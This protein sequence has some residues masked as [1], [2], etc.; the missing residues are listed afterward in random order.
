MNIRGAFLRRV[1]CINTSAFF[2]Q[3]GSEMTLET[4]R[5]CLHRDLASSSAAAAENLRLAE[6]A[7]T[8]ARSCRRSLGLE[9]VDR[10]HHTVSLEQMIAA[11]EALVKF[12]ERADS[13]SLGAEAVAARRRLRGH[14]VRIVGSRVGV[15]DGVNDDGEV[16]LAWNWAEDEDEDEGQ[17][18]GGGGDGL[19]SSSLFF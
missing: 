6:A 2:H 14:C 11:C 4:L 8:T 15:S 1:I 10:A 16:I 5:R 3:V 7:S 13:G 18:K 19:R 9:A 17:R 12:G